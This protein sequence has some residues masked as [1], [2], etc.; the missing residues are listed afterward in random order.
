MQ[1]MGKNG[2]KVRQVLLLM[3]NFEDFDINQV[4]SALRSTAC[5]TLPQNLFTLLPP[6]F[7]RHRAL[8]A[9]VT[10]PHATASQVKGY[11]AS[12]ADL[13]I[14]DMLEHKDEL[15]AEDDDAPFLIDDDE[16]EEA[17][18]AAAAAAGPSGS[19]AVPTLT[20]ELAPAAAAATAASK[21]PA[22]RKG[23]A[24]SKK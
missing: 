2:I 11:D 7:T 3:R 17:A 20:L 10:T 22:T 4:R 24:A 6:A 1:T 5:T 18:A 19:A 16:E 13:I 8:P 9:D 23:A 15:L 21:V 12:T 14:A